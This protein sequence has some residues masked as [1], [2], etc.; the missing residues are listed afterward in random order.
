M[1]WV[2]KIFDKNMVLLYV[3]K[4]AD[5]LNRPK[6]HYND[7]WGNE[8][9]EIILAKCKSKTDMDI[10]ET[11]YINK[12][13]P[14]YNRAKVMDEP[15]ISLPEFDTWL[16][17]ETEC[18]KRILEN[19]AKNES[20]NCKSNKE[21]LLK[22]R[23][24]DVILKENEKINL[25]FPKEYS[26]NKSVRY[27]FKEFDYI[28]ISPCVKSCTFIDDLLL[29]FLQYGKKQSNCSNKLKISSQIEDILQ[30]LNMNL[31]Q[32]SINTLT[33]AM[34]SIIG[35]NVDGSNWG[36]HF[37]SDYNMAVYSYKNGIIFNGTINFSICHLGLLAKHFTLKDIDFKTI[38]KKCNIEY[39]L[40]GSNIYKRF[41]G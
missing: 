7:P 34:H 38:F 36:L 6:A 2:Y 33:I 39:S 35:I 21:S 3:G 37:F 9:D 5:F 10:Y 18:K 4:T 31:N 14:K 24:C 12:L 40:E 19:E 28:E 1:Y 30:H 13:K 20:N 22:P 11:Y 41:T 27:Y 25:F 8:I 15:Y 29:Y 23:N 16:D 26:S 17:Y 32:E